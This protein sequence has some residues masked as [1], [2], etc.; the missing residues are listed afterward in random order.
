MNKQINKY[1]KLLCKSWT[2]PRTYGDDAEK[3]GRKYLLLFNHRSG[4]GN[5]GLKAIFTEVLQQSQVH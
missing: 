5:G 1:P 4:I 3:E 2:L